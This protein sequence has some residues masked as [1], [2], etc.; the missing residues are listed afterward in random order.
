MLAMAAESHAIPT[1]DAFSTH[2][3]L[4]L[5][6]LEDTRSRRGKQPLLSHARCSVGVRPLSLSGGVPLLKNF[7]SNPQ[8]L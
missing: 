4:T 1:F 5:R 2:S 3:N 6:R 8:S 7:L